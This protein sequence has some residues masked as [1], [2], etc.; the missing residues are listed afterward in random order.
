VTSSAR[1]CVCAAV[2]AVL[3]LSAPLPADEPRLH[4]VVRQDFDVRRGWLP[5]WR[6]A[7]DLGKETLATRSVVLGV[8]TGHE[9]TIADDAC[10]STLELRCA[11]FGGKLQLHHPVSEIQLTEQMTGETNSDVF[12]L[13]D[14][15]IRTDRQTDR[16]SDAIFVDVLWSVG[17]AVS[18][19]DFGRHSAALTRRSGP[20]GADGP[21]GLGGPSPRVG[22]RRPY[23]LIDPPSK[24]SAAWTVR[25]HRAVA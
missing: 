1:T 13:Y 3:V 11:Q 18:Y 4:F 15:R 8:L 10:R 20:E 23:V 5:T 25:G 22:W 21:R 2:S 6:R 9:S 17:Q 7:L 16:Y 12:P 24:A 19:L 14:E